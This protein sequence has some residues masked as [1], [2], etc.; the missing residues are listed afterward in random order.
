VECEFLF[1][2]YFMYYTFQNKISILTWCDILEM[3]E[4]GVFLFGMLVVNNNY[5]NG[6]MTLESV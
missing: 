1:G 4:R 2:A 5:W 6:L 3:L